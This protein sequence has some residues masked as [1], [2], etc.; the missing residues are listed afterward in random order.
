MFNK[1]LRKL[2]F[3]GIL[4]LGLSFIFVSGPNSIFENKVLALENGLARTPPMGW[5]S[6]NIFGGS[7][8]ETKIK[9]IA[10]VMVSSGMK[11]AGYIYLNLD[12][13]W[14]KNPAR[15][16]NGNLVGDPTRFPSGMKALGDYIHSKGLKFGIYS[17]RGTMTC[18]GI[19][20]SGGHNNETRDA[21][22]YASW[23]VDYLKYDNCNAD[24]D[25][26]ADYER[27]RDALANCGRPICYSICCWSWQ[28]SWL[29]NCGNLWRTTGDINDSWG[30]MLGNYDINLKL[31]PYGGPGHWNDP[32]MLE[33]GNGHMTDTEY[34]THMS[35]WCVMAAPLIAGNDIRTMS[36]ATKDILLASEV[37]AV[38]QDAAGVQG[39]KVNGSGD[40]EVICKPLGTA[41]TTKAIALVNRGTSTLNITVNWAD[42]G[43]AAG[44]ATVR[45][46]WAKV[47]RGSF[48]NSY[49][50]S[51][52]SHGT[53]LLKITGTSGGSVCKITKQDS[54]TI[55]DL[56]VTVDFYIDSKLHTDWEDTGTLDSTSNL[57]LN[58]WGGT[59]DGSKYTGNLVWLQNKNSGSSIVNINKVDARPVTNMRVY[60]N[61]NINGEAYYDYEDCGNFTGT[62][63][64]YLDGN[65]GSWDGTKW[66]GN[67]L[68]H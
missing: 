22:T 42:I 41:G 44:T 47:D 11:N 54:R 23:G 46:L 63:Q 59:W 35:L 12:D 55:T 40:W 38:D 64:L 1:H 29:I 20:Q 4:V 53:A 32:D 50:V 24:A 10:D 2:I 49:T 19:P 56:R 36:Q 52:P 67:F 17:D 3:L 8:D 16:G 37:I 27:M 58:G 60:T 68:K 13:N 45:D 62:I 65:G 21:N 25:L 48:T 6:W 28:G 14:M 51:V 34:R 33:I 39:S 31:T 30:S 61:F 57:G 66:V 43:L 15:D 9:Q 18:M 5:N 26:Q 7:I